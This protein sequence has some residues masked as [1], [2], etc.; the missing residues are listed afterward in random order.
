MN[1]VVCRVLHAECKS[2]AASGFPLPEPEVLAPGIPPT[3]AHDLLFHG[4]KTIR[5]LTFANLYAADSA[6]H[7]SDMQNIDRALSSAMTDVNLNNVMAQY[8]GR[9]PPTRNLKPSHTP[10]GFPTPHGS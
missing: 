3:P 9:Q 4:G 2:H 8:F 6:W 5:N 1:H 7:Q 10:P